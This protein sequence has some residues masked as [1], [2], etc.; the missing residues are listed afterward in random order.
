LAEKEGW[1]EEKIW[2]RCMEICVGVLAE[3]CETVFFMSNY[4]DSKGAMG[5][6]YIA[7]LLKKEIIYEGDV[8]I[9]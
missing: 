9:G 3:L 5:E 7:K 8:L 2:K 6:N 4:I 1:S